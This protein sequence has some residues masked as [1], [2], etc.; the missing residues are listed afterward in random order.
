MKKLNSIISIL[1]I[2]SFVGCA[3]GGFQ[4]DVVARDA[5]G[6][7]QYVQTGVVTQVRSVVIEGDRDVG[8][9]SGTVLGAIVGSGAAGRAAGG[10][11]ETS[12]QIGAIV[13]G[14]VG[15]VV[16]SEVGES[17]SRK[18]GVAEFPDAVT[19]RGLKHINELLKANKKGFEIYLFYVI[20]RDDCKKFDLAKDIDPDYCELLLKAVKKKLNILCYDCKFST[21]GI[22]LNRKIK[23]NFNE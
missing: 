7:S 13:G 5:A 9:T 14:L 12:E 22:K 11:G 10:D 21:K 20:Q 17:I 23:L 15:S 4:A 18:K 16:G 3:T 19:S 6:K 2:L 1:A 8:A